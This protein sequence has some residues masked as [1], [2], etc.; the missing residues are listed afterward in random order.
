MCV[1]LFS[2]FPVIRLESVD[3]PDHQ[4]DDDIEQ[5]QRGSFSN[6]RIIDGEDSFSSDSGENTFLRV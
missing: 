4:S 2:F 3:C 1:L 5:A 6:K